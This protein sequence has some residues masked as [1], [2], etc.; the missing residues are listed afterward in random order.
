MSA[1]EELAPPPADAIQIS[2]A[3][4]AAIMVM[5]LDDEQAA[6]ILSRLEPQELRLLG[7]K[8]CALG[9]IRPELI[10]HAIAGFVDRT[11][12]LGLAPHDR[13]GHVRSLM[14]RAVGQTK[15]EN[16]MQRI[17][18]DEAK[19]SPIELAR[20]LNPEA[21]AP[22]VQGEHPQA[23]AVLLVQLDPEVAAEVL[24]GLP[25][26]SQTQIIHRIATLGPVSA[27]AL[28]MLEEVLARRIA[29]S[30]G[31]SMLEMGG[32]REAADIINS[33]SKAVEKRVMAGNRQDG[34]GSRAPDRGRDVQVRASLRTGAAGD[35]RLAARS[36]KRRT[37]RFT[38]GHCRGRTRM[39][40]PRHVE[41]CRR[42]GQ[43]RD[44]RARPGQTGR[45]GRGAETGRGG[46]PATGC[47]TAQFRS[48]RPRAM[49]SMS[50]GFSPGWA[51]AFAEHVPAA[52]EWLASPPGAG[53]GDSTGFRSDPRFS[54]AA[55]PEIEREPEVEPQDPLA[56]AWAEG[57]AA[58]AEHA[59][60]EAVRAAETEAAAR[61]ALELSFIRLDRELAE[62]LR[63]Q[64]RDTV[65]AL[66]E[67]SPG[68][69]GAG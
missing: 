54:A 50:E 63:Q 20:W 37:D 21:L 32:V 48:A 8:M 33:S 55:E 66:C 15:A 46:S 30:H 49:T 24:H 52:Q 25:P 42:R 65:A 2:E 18:P 26:E 28:A 39:L 56:Q 14:T 7:E 36:G 67:A 31:T 47:A 13:V 23:I 27:E 61:D 17:A 51:P 57:Y 53:F 59:R 19:P 34:Q 60:G 22:L 11:E 4:R 58:G 40:L 3:D 41:P 68:T 43:G 6:N 64:L 35:G 16:L 38:Q 9:E 62:Q 44:R 12:R 1:P 45:C 69:A 5:L 10:A 29:E